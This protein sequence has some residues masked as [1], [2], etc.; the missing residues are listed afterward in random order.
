MIAAGPRDSLIPIGPNG[1]GVGELMFD[2]LF[3]KFAAGAATAPTMYTRAVSLSLLYRIHLTLWSLLG[4][5]LL[6][7]DRVAGTQFFIAGA[8]GKG[9]PGKELYGVLEGHLRVSGEREDGEERRTRLAGCHEH[10][11]DLVHADE[12]ACRIVFL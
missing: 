6:V 11:P 12:A 3:P 4:G 2:Y 9:D 7:L 1:W 10:T 5:L 8:N